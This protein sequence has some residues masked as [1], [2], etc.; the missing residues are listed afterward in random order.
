MSYMNFAMIIL[1]GEFQN[2]KS[3]LFSTKYAVFVLVNVSI[4]CEVAER[5]K[6]N[7]N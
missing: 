3:C 7:S 1:I 2:G 4:E 5:E 6:G